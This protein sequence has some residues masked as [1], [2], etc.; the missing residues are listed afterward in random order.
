MSKKKPAVRKVEVMGCSW[1]KIQGFFHHSKSV[2][3]KFAC[4]IKTIEQLFRYIFSISSSSCAILYI[5]V[6]LSLNHATNGM[7]IAI[8]ASSFISHPSSPAFCDKN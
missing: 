7:L 1:K 8:H 3:S 2:E 4:K 6:L 5:A